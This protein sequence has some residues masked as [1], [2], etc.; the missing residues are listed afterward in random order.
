[1]AT[2]ETIK[3]YYNSI[4]ARD[5]TEAE[6]NTWTSVSTSG[7]VTDA[8]I[9]QALISS[10]ESSAFVA[11]VLRLYQA[12]FG[13]VPESTEAIKF[14]ADQ[15]RAS[16]NAGSDE[17]NST[18]ARFSLQFSESPE[19][20][21]R[22]GNSDLSLGFLTALYSNVLGREPD[23]AGLAFYL[24][25]QNGFDT[26]RILLGFSASPEFQQ[27]VSAS[28]SN[29]LGSA[30]QGEAV[31]T[32]PLLGGLIGETF[33]LTTSVDQLTG[34]AN[35]DTFN[36]APT[37]ADV[38]LQF[39]DS[40]D[41]GAGSDTLKFIQSGAFNGVPTGVTV[42]NV[43]NVSILGGAGVAINTSSGFSGLTNLTT[44]SVAAVNAAAAATT[45]VVATVTGATAADGS[46]AV[47][48][49][50]NVTL[51]VSGTTAD[52]DTAAE[53]VVGNVAAPVGA[54]SVSSTFAGA[55]A[56]KQADI[57]IT[58]G[59]QITVTETLTN[60]VNTTNTQGNVSVIGGAA[61]TSVTVTQDTAAT[62][63]ATVAGKANGDVA[64][65]DVNAASLTAA[66]TIETVTLNNFGDAA[67]SS[68]ALKTLNL[69]GTGTSVNAGT[70]GALTTPANTALAL[71]VNGLITTGAVTID[72]DITTLNVGSATAASTLNSLSAAGVRALNVSGDAAVTLSGHSMGALETVVVTNTAGLSMSGAPLAAGASFTGGAGADAVSLVA[73]TKAIAMG[74]GDDTVTVGV[75]ALGTG[76]SIDAGTGADTLTMTAANAVTA[77]GSTAFGAAISNFEKLV[78]TDPTGAQTVNLANLDSL[79]YVSTSTIAAT[80]LTLSNLAAAS[81]LEFTGGDVASQVTV[82]LADATGTAD[83]LNLK[84]TAAGNVNAGTVTASDVETISINSDDTAAAPAGTVQHSVTVVDAAAKSIVVTGDAGLALTHTGT[85]LASFDASGVT[86]GGINFT[87]G[88]LVNAATLTGSAGNDTFDAQAIVAVGV[89]I[90]GGA[91]DDTITGAAVASNLSGGAGNDAITGGNG[92]DSLSGGDGDDTL[93]GGA[94]ADNLSGGAGNDIITGGLGADSLSGGA[95]VDTFVFGTNG[96]LAGT[97]LDVISD[98]NAG[99]TGDIL[100][101]G[102]AAIVLAADT[103]PPVAGSNV[104]T[105]AGGKIIFPGADTTFT[106]QLAAVQ[107]DAELD[108]IGSVAF[109]ENSGN[110][111]VYYAGAAIGDTDD[112][113]VQ[114]AG[115]TGLT[116]I[117]VS[118]GDLL[119]V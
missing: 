8:G 9:R 17:Y 113:V 23:P 30:A 53:I 106:Q 95:G 65:T 116:T 54:V 59:T 43:E 68:G 117:N 111:Y 60:A 66:G 12:A 36:V 89:T 46:V 84:V 28:I 32:G 64:I 92:A 25:P 107:A 16:G 94:G 35:N 74:A 86:T 7:A 83:V 90:N 99:G 27:R 71:N 2:A 100:D 119:F 67:I 80:N 81:T 13:R 87:T 110:T 49:G 15:L 102:G 18:L 85:A 62:A 76:G 51:T 58:G 3:I 19:F 72:G 57:A 78:L 73:T 22:Y 105:T 1:M 96:S 50:K 6:T 77:S 69:S 118:S 39:G 56:E 38:L 55:G 115:L 79:N 88:A 45:D 47:N 33:T 112:Q 52:A 14:Y 37:G 109:W 21:G 10:A 91:G 104:N 101:F 103:S 93:T 114:L 34:T 70:L 48:G 42:S 26:Q 29:F 97:S 108:A 11:P 63:S 24:D 5:P 98:F 40:I 75:A 4:L 44:T 82:G 61:T 20:T 31:F 41:G